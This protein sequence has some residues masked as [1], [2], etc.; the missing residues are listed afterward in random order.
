M[1]LFSPEKY[2]ENATSLL[3]EM[4]VIER[5]EKIILQN[6]DKKK[7]SFVSLSEMLSLVG[8][9][10]F[11]DFSFLEKLL[12]TNQLSSKSKYCVT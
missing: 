10:H 9:W 1:T 5:L 3:F 6:I 4:R 8:R 2:L 7:H 12:V 11:Q